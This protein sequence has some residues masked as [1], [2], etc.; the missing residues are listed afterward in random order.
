M[1]R[2]QLR[3]RGL[4]GRVWALSWALLGNRRHSRAK[5]AQPPVCKSAIV[6]STPTGASACETPAMCRQQRPSQ[7]FFVALGSKDEQRQPP[8]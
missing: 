2:P 7:G 1:P 8:D 4:H 3:G 6:G 5:Q